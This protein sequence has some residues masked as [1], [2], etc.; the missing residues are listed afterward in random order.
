MKFQLNWSGSRGSRQAHT[1]QL[2]SFR[3]R[4]VL[5]SK[6]SL[7][8]LLVALWW[9]IT[10]PVSAAERL[11][12]RLGPFEQ[13]V[14]IAD[15]E[16]FAETGEMTKGLKPY[17]RLLTPQVRQLLVRR[18]QID[19][20][21]TEK[22]VNDLLH[23]PDGARLLKRIGRVLPDSS[24]E[25]LQAALFLAARQA[26]GLSVLSFL[27]AYPEDSV[28]VDAT[29]MA[30]IA[31]QLNS[32][33]LQSLAIGPML[34]RELT[35]AE[36]SGLPLDFDPAETGSEYVRE[37]TLRLRDRPRGRTILV[38]LYW[39]RHSDGPLVVLSHGFGSDRKFLRYIGRH[40]A[41]H[42][43]TVASL[44]HPGSNFN[45]INGVSISGNPGDLVPASEFIERP[46]DVSFMLDQLA[47]LNYRYGSLKGK[48]NTKQVS[49][50]GHS[51]GGYTALALAGGELDLESLRQFCQNRSPIGRSPADWFQC[52][53]TEL[54]DEYFG[55]QDR[56][57]AQVIALNAM[58][59]RLFG[60][61]G[62][63]RVKTPTLILTGT[64]DAITP[65]VDNHLRPFTQLGGSKYLL[66]A[67]GG[68][69][70]SVTDK[71][72]LNDAMARSTLVKERVGE[73]VDPL[74]QLLKGVS[75]AF[76][77]QLTPEAKTYE[78]FLKPAYAQSFSTPTLS[79]RLS[80]QLPPTMA[81]WF[82]VLALPQQRVAL[83]LPKL[84]NFS[85]NAIKSNFSPS[86]NAMPRLD[87]HTGK[88]NRVFTELL[89]NY[90]IKSDHPLV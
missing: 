80:T 42:G 32:S 26:N 18:L 37:R 61:R 27:E 63:A 43:L 44:E 10:A 81:S 28:V 13:S 31:L 78:P 3:N 88:L 22:F 36:S 74:R 55:L 76:I 65:S 21:M 9:G 40:L 71:G 60:S 66:A 20:N 38:D 41:S 24:L 34:E 15:L 45:W 69:H 51:F 5:S 82:Q 2:V 19:P 6:S 16:K 52:A 77:K 72:N 14:S 49:V 90:E 85:L 7:C 39:S 59:G 23:S 1:E 33:Y 56:R 89:E 30:A 47:K 86:A 57:V 70:L 4:I 62:L 46:K 79:L 8:T 64:E 87:R 75:L 25:Q 83:R 53:A 68:T 17:S 54:P 48:L 58:T 11:T 84:S 29:S 67:I 73:E 35:V 12:L 50:I